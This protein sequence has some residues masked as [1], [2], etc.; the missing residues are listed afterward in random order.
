MFCIILSAKYIYYLFS[1]QH[2]WFWVVKGIGFSNQWY[3]S[4]I[5]LTFNGL[6]NSNIHEEGAHLISMRQG[7]IL[8]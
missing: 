8:Q 4:S 1:G 5:S 2:V 6:T 7:G 3:K